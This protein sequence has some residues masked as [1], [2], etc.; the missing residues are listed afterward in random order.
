MSESAESSSVDD[1][2]EL[3][4]VKEIKNVNISEAEQEMV[5]LKVLLS[6]NFH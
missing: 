6:Y 2:L 3:E 1:S 4:E 5:L